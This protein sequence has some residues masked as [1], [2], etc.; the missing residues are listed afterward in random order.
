MKPLSSSEIIAKCS[1]GNHELTDSHGGNDLP[2]MLGQKSWQTSIDYKNTHFVL[3]PEDNAK[4]DPI[5]LSND[6]ASAR[7][8]A[9]IRWIVVVFHEPIYTSES[10]HA[11]KERE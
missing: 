8:N 3:L 4:P 6:L 7:A 9:H 11:P 2:Q 10:A 5:W 1:E